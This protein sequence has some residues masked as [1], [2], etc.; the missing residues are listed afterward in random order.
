MSDV[1]F[2]D[3]L[4]NVKSSKCLRVEE[5]QFDFII[6]D[7]CPMFLNQPT[8]VSGEIFTSDITMSKS[9]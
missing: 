4:M 8:G 7:S 5:A 1:I 9:K 3:Y 6:A 2:R